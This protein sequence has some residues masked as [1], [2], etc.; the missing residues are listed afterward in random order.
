MHCQGI[1]ITLHSNVLGVC[2]PLH[3]NVWRTK[4]SD[5]AYSLS[6]FL[7]HLAV[8]QIHHCFLMHYRP[9]SISDTLFFYTWYYFSSGIILNTLLFYTRYLVHPIGCIFLEHLAV[10]QTHHCFLMHYLPCSISDTLLFSYA[11]SSAYARIFQMHYFS[12]VV[13]ST[14]LCHHFKYIVIFCVSLLF[15]C[16]IIP[17]MSLFLVRHHFKYMVI[18]CAFKYMVISYGRYFTHVVISHIIISRLSLFLT[19]YYF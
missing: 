2:F 8:F 18:S 6:I 16:V 10:L 5:E 14:C 3:S 7:E 1:C 12:K 17:Y 9:C 13:I 15:F 11:S 4:S 19:Y